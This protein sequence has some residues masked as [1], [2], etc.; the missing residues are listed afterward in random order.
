MTPTFEPTS[1]E[2]PTMTP[3]PTETPT[4]TPTVDVCL[5]IECITPTFEPSIV[6]LSMGGPCF[7]DDPACPTG[8]ESGEVG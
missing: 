2:T 4:I 7:D 1:T 6:P 3:T 5:L 8:S